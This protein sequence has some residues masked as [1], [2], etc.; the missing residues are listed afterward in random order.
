MINMMKY[1]YVLLSF[2]FATTVLAQTPEDPPAELDPPAT[3]IEQ[4]LY[5]LFAAAIAFG[6]VSVAKH[7]KKLSCTK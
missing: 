3:S 1:K 2:L 6:L 5:V 4:N 7:K